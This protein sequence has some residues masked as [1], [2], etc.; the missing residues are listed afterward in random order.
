MPRKHSLE[1]FL[2]KAIEIHGNKYDYSKVDYM[3]ARTKVCIICPEHGKFW[4]APDKHINCCQG[5]PKC[6]G[7]EKPT[8][9][10]FFKKANK[11]HN[12]KYDYSEVIYNNKDS[13]IC[14][15]CHQKDKNGIEHGRFYP[16][17]HNHLNGNGCPKCV[18]K[19]RYATNE[20]IEKF[21]M[22]HHEA[23][24]YSKV[25]YVNT[26]TKVCIICPEHGEFWQA[27]YHH[28]NGNGCPHCK[29]SLFEKRVARF[30]DKNKIHYVGHTNCILLPWLGRQH[31]DF[32][33]PDYNIA[34][35]C[36]GEQHYFPVD[37]AGNGTEWAKSKFKQTKELDKRKLNLCNQNG[38]KLTYI[39]FDDDIEVM[40]KKILNL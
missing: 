26:R 1:E 28:L 18:N 7:K 11:V 37:F 13:K 30:L 22:I 34:I 10:E 32:Y 23:Y 12:N 24:D 14:V 8:T 19:Y 3:N 2:K 20:I 38:V 35:E 31:L 27:P 5:C 33:L 16:I 39:K 21:K 25:E 29:T 17:A 15:I 40:I 36:Q 9:E 4:Q 6:S